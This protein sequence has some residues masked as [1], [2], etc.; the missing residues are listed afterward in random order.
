MKSHEKIIMNGVQID[1]GISELIQTLWDNGIE[2]IQ[3]C[4]GGR[5]SSKE[6]MFT[7]LCD[8]KIIENAHIIF[9]KRDLDRIKNFLPEN[10]DYI[11]GDANRRGHIAE[12]LGS[13]DGAWA[14]FIHKIK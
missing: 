7:R 11:I 3:C 14:N 4:E 5:I 6:T 12:W 1:K 9:Y 8:G 10:T 2:T 13:F